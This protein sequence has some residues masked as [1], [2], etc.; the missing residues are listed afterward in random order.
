MRRG[1]QTIRSGTVEVIVL[2]P[3]DTTTWRTETIDDHV[4]AVRGA[5]EVTLA[6]WPGA[7]SRPALLAGTS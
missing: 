4:A 5:F 6:S 3:V 1:D 7:P 2:P